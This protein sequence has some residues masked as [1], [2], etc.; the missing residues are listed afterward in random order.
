MDEKRFTLRLDSE[1]FNKIQKLAEA[2][3]RST[4]KE[5]EN[6]LAIY[7]EKLEQDSQDT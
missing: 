6:I 5:I 7:L 1:I 2:N 3:R 4:A